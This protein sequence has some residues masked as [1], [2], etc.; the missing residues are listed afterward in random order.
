MTELRHLQLVILNIAKDIDE[1]CIRNGI[2]YTL[3]GG[4]AIGAIRHKGFIPWDDDFDIQ[5]TPPN[6]Y[7]FITSCHEQ[8]DKTKYYFEEGLVD[9][10]LDFCKVKLRGTRIDELE[11]YAGKNNQLGIFIDIFRIDGAAP[12]KIGRA[13]QYFCA[14]Y[15]MAFLMHKRG[16]KSASKLKKLAMALSILQ[17]IP[18]V[19]LFF[20]HEKEKYDGE[21]TG[22]YAFLS[23]RITYQQAFCRKEVFAGSKRVPFEDTLFPVP[24]LYDEYLRGIFGDYMQLPPIEQQVPTHHTRIEFGKY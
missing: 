21:R 9:W 5:M 23:E 11:N 10:P 18:C 7:K 13:W 16:Y 1:L 12:T 2:E 4:S 17:Y 15:R 19:E 3:N 20:K 24:N 8:L 22:Y 14:R 6:Y